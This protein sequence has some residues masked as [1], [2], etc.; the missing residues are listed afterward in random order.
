M[1]GF[2]DVTREEEVEY[3]WGKISQQ[4]F[5]SSKEKKKVISI[6]ENANIFNHITI[7]SN[8]EAIP[9]Y[10]Y[11]DGEVLVRCIYHKGNGSHFMTCRGS[12][13]CRG[14]VEC[15]SNQ[16]TVYTESLISPKSITPPPYCLTYNPFVRPRKNVTL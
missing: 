9:I 14:S 10:K 16:A 4:T 5:Q 11:A 15:I 13:G 7:I 8:G 1:V 12:F 6:T 3:A 2:K